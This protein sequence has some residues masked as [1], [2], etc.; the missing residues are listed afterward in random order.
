V[1]AKC[2]DVKPPDACLLLGGGDLIGEGAAQE[3]G[4]VGETPK[5]CSRR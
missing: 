2:L 5:L 4:V 1:Q 3:R